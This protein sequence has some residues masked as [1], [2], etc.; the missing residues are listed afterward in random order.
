VNLLFVCTHNRCR[1]I[2]AEAIT[3]HIAGGALL[4]RS[5]GS[6]PVGE[7]HPLTLKYLGERGIDTTGLHS[8]G[9]GSMDGPA[10]EIVITVCDRAAGETCPLWLGDAEKVHWSLADPS[11]IEGPESEQR[12]AF[13]ATMATL[14]QRLRQ[15]LQSGAVHAQPAVFAQQ[16]RDLAAPVN[17]GAI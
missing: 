7:V 4:A 5:A 6:S 3:N 2:L 11:A 9:W 8:K 10:P 16:M 12:A 13:Y 14:E 17:A 1:S 15:L